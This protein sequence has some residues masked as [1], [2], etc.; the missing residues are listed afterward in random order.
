MRVTWLF[1]AGALLAATA[2]TARANYPLAYPYPRPTAPDA[3]GGGFWCTNP[4]GMA[5]GP[6]YWVRPPFPPHTPLGPGVPQ[7]GGAQSG[8]PTHPY[9]RSPRDFF[10]LD[11]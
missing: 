7:F 6:N 8:F 9:A 10:M 5:Y 11:N 2:G 3:C 4:C 1:L